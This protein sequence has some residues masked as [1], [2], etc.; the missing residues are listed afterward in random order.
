MRFVRSLA[1]LVLVSSA[2]AAPKPKPA[3]PTGPALAATKSLYLRS[4]FDTDP[5]LYLGRFIPDGTLKGDLDESRGMQTQCSRHI[6]YKTVGGGDV[7]YD[8]LYTA[9]TGAS[10]SAQ[11][12]QVATIS[13]GVSTGTTV[14]VSYRMTEK[15]V[16][17]ISDPDKYAACCARAPDQ[18]P[19]EYIG[20]FVSGTGAV[21]YANGLDVGAKVKVEPSVVKSE[22]FPKLEVKHGQSWSRGIVFEN[23]VFFGF[24]LYPNPAKP[25]DWDCASESVPLSSL[26]YYFV[27]VSPQVGDEA[28]A[29][30]DA[31]F[32]ARKRVVQFVGEQIMSGEVTVQGATSGAPMQLTSESWVEGAASGLATLVQNQKTCVEKI[33]MPNGYEY[34][35]RALAYVPNASVEAAAAKLAE[36]AV[37]AAPAAVPA[38]VMAQPA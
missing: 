34:R 15:L 22:L 36:P 14:R 33:P 30:D 4:A 23:P 29:R 9:S 11:I 18:C 6:Q 35:A 19:A 25:P 1:L 24:K 8:E 3:P 12:P 37:P 31:M 26:G 2:Q 20:E 16:S 5:S 21:Y 10:I 13:A 27:G 17:F 28:K 38:P 7:A 32:N